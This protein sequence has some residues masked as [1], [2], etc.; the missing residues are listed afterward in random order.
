MNP[1][2]GTLSSPLE[3]LSGPQPDRGSKSTARDS[4]INRFVSYFDLD[5]IAFLMAYL[6]RISYFD[7][8]QKENYLSQKSF[9]EMGCS[10]KP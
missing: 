10:Q 6:T 1:I 7:P 2:F 8:S 4:M 5:A 3:T 9:M